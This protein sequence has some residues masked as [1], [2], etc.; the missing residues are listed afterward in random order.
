MRLSKKYIIG[1]VLCFSIF[2]SIYF[3]LVLYIGINAE[4]DTKSKS[5]VILVL[6]AKSYIDGK[7]NPCL[8]SRVSHA[9][10]LYKSKYASKILMTGG[11]DKEDNVNEAETM[12]NIAV[13]SGVSRDD[14]LLE[15]SA[16][17]TYENFNLSKEVLNRNG[18]KSVIIITEPFHIARAALV[19]K[20][21]NYNYTISPAKE[22]TCWVPNKYLSKYFLKE[23][24]VISV[25]KIQNKL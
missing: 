8:V 3:V 24:F 7:Y 6:G 1:I 21:L 14:I 10:D 16:T 13:E 9:V 17:S 18:L 11:N 15:K 5:D 19:A 23:P 20:K 25:Y 22:S 4:H 12:R 2:L